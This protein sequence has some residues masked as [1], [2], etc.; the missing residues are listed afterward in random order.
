MLFMYKYIYI[1][2]I[3]SERPCIHIYIERAPPLDVKKQIIV[4][5]LQQW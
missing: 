4:N 5:M 3:W 1:Q 2:Y